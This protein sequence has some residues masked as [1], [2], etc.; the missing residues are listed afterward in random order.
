MS[1]PLNQF[2]VSLIPGEP[3]EFLDLRGHRLFEPRW[4]L[5]HLRPIPG[6]VGAIAIGGQRCSL[7]HKSFA[8]SEECLA[9]LHQP[10]PPLTPPLIR[11]S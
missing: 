8:T 7:S 9:D 4:T 2:R 5:Y 10:K 11:L 3:A 6:F 1:A